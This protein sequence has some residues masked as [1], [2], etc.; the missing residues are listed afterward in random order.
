MNSNDLFYNNFKTIDELAWFST[1]INPKKEEWL[2]YCNPSEARLSKENLIHD[3]VRHDWFYRINQYGFRGVW[4]LDP[5]SIKIGFFGCSNTFGLGINEPF[6]FPKL[7]EKY[8]QTGKVE[9]L[10]LGCTG[11]SVQR[12]AKLLSASLKFIR[13]NLVILNLPTSS[14]FLVTSQLRQLQDLNPRKAEHERDEKHKVI[15]ILSQLDLDMI[16]SDYIKWMLTEL[17][18]LGINSLWTSWCPD[19]YSVLESLIDKDYLLPSADLTKES[20]GARD[21]QHPNEQW[22]RTQAEHIIKRLELLRWP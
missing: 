6:I 22:H 13:F 19:T 8:F 5:S 14:R 2:Y 21:G 4:R 16:T 17:K 7:V 11:S 20:Q 15:Q 1:V 9:S 12:I 10:N 3:P 18:T